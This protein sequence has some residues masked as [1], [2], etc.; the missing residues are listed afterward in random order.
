MLGNYYKYF[1]K[2]IENIVSHIFSVELKATSIFSIIKAICC[3][4]KLSSA[5]LYHFYEVMYIFSFEH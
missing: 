1:L 2:Y 5:H 3:Y 4:Q